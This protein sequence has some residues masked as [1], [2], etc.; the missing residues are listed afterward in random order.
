M[1]LGDFPFDEQDVQV[2]LVSVSHTPEQVHLIVDGG[3]CGR[4]ERLT[5]VD[6]S[7][8]PGTFR[9][10][11]IPVRPG[12]PALAG[13]R[14]SFTAHRYANYYILKVI[15]PLLIII[16]M[17]FS[18]FWI[19]PTQFGPR[20]SVGATAVLTLIAYRFALGSLVPRVSYLTRLDIFILGATIIVLL[21]LIETL[22]V[23]W[24]IELDRRERSTALDRVA[25]V[26]GLAGLMGLML[27]AFAL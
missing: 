22:A 4:E 1:S 23:H 17:S 16:L 12:E 18:A 25:R 19:A 26:V 11:P 3:F 14:A 27:L 10:E 24:Y 15:T 2:V 20:V 13:F 8:G 7:I 5:V 9:A 21:A 6:W